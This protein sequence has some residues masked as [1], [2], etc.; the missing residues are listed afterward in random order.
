MFDK[1]FNGII[2]NVQIKRIA[3]DKG[4]YLFVNITLVATLSE[5]MA[6]SLG[7][8]VDDIFNSEINVKNMVINV[9]NVVIDESADGLVLDVWDEGGDGTVTPYLNLPDLSM[10]KYK[11]LKD[12]DSGDVCFH[13]TLKSQPISESDILRV[14]HCLDNTSL[15]SLVYAQGELNV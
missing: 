10:K 5:E 12:E 11:L 9:K 3:F 1:K 2:T 8:N 4:G 6:N 13:V 14:I 15:F 7:G